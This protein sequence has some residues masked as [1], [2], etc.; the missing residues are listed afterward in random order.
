M[1]L[2]FVER[3]GTPAHDKAIDRIDFRKNADGTFEL[4]IT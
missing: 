2:L 3:T 4:H 1:L